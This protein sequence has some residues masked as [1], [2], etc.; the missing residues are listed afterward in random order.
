M[1]IQWSFDEKSVQKIFNK[2]I[3]GGFKSKS[4]AK[5]HINIAIKALSCSNC[6]NKRLDGGNL[7]VD[8]TKTHLYDQKESKGIFGSK[9]VDKFDR[10]VFII[11]DPYLASGGFFGGSGWIKCR[12]C[13]EKSSGFNAFWGQWANN[14]KDAYNRG[15][16][17]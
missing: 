1:S 15:D 17:R 11:S 6:G 9:L 5:K 2:S 8:I 7:L 3:S 4:E 16:F 14:L 12:N 13:G 10:T